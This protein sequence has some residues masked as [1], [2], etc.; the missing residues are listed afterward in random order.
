MRELLI[1]LFGATVLWLMVSLLGSDAK[2]RAGACDKKYPIDY[3][4]FSRFFCEIKG[5]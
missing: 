5:E 2:A 4:I 3:L 1:G